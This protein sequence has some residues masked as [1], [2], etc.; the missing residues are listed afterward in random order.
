[1]PDQLYDRTSRRCAL[2]A[3]DPPLRA[4]L[5]AE[6]ELQRLGDLSAVVTA[7]VE[8]R[9]VPRRRRGAL[10]RLLGGGPTQA[11]LTAA[12]LTPRHLLL[13]VTHVRTGSTTALCGRLDDMTVTEVDPRLVMD[14]GVSVCARWSNHCEAGSMRVGLG[15][16]PVG[17]W[18]KDVLR[19]AVQETRRAQGD[20][21]AR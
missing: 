16:D 11:S 10:S 15:D 18:F 1:M 2:D 3:L 21:R 8:T 5:L 9:S 7:C 4:A 19:R 17:V 12:V 6:A 14:S 20:D 13:A